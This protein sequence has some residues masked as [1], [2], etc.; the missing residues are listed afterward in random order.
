MGKKTSH[1][2]LK[3]TGGPDLEASMAVALTNLTSVSSLEFPGFPTFP[4]GYHAGCGMRSPGSGWIIV[5]EVMA[6]AR[7]GNPPPLVEMEVVG[8]PLSFRLQKKA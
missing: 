1:L 2:W 4:R 3:P 7:E 6:A 5:L 8:I